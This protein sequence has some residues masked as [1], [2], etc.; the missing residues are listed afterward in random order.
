ME[1][2]SYKNVVVRLDDQKRAGNKRRE[3]RQYLVVAESINSKKRWEV[4]LLDEIV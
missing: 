2:Q 1:T 4:S 3:R